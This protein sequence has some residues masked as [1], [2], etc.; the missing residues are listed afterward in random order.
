MPDSDRWIIKTKRFVA[1][2][3]ILG[4]KDYVL[5]HDINDVYE[6][7]LTLNEIKPGKS[8]ED[9]FSPEY[10][11]KL[12]FTAFSDSIFLFTK[13]DSL[14]N[15]R[16]L[17]LSLNRMIRMAFRAGIPLKGAIAS[18]EMVVDLEKSLFC[19]QPITDAY[20]LEEDLQYMGIVVH[21]SVERMIKKYKEHDLDFSNKIFKE[22]S[23]PFKYGNRIH[24]NLNFKRGLS[25]VFSTIEKSIK[26][27]RFE[28]SG[29]ARKY[30]DNTLEMLKAFEKM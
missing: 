30:V 12:I 23:T 15:L 7:L 9:D 5:R 2:C 25:R 24:Y 10:G 18:G 1:F 29:D 28:T 13:D 3:D 22:V 19:G 11:S 17:V 6:R 4:F 26:V 8:K 27:Q 14:E 21:H 16:H 20:L